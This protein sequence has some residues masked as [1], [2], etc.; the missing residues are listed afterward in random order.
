M[1]SFVAELEVPPGTQDA[2]VLLAS[3]SMIVPL[4]SYF[5]LSPILGFLLAGVLLGPNGLHLVRDVH[6]T[7]VL[8]ELGVVFFLFEMGLELSIERLKS[9]SK[10][11]FGLGTF[12]FVLTTGLLALV[13][14]LCGLPR[15]AA[16]VVGGS[17]ALSSSA[18]VIQLLQER[19][20]LATRFGRASFG[21][22]L[23]QDI[24]VV[25]MLVLVPLLGTAGAGQS[26]GPVLLTAAAK[27]AAALAAIAG[28]GPVLLRKAFSVVS[29][30]KSQEA[31]VAATLFTVLS[32]STF[33]KALGLS[34]T[35][36]AFLAGV[37]LAE[38]RFRYQVEADIAPFRGILFGLF[39]ITIGYAIDIRLL[40][41]N[42]G[43]LTAMLVTL[44]AIKALILIFLCKVA[45][46]S[47]RS[48]IRTGVLLS[49][50]GEFAFVL[51]GLARQHGV[52]D[53]ELA[54]LLLLLAALSMS[55]TPFLAD[56]GPTLAARW[57]RRRR[58]Q[59]VVEQDKDLQD[60]KQEGQVLVCG[61]GRVGQV[62]C[63]LLAN[64]FVRYA[65]C[66][67][68]AELVR[69][70]RDKGLPVYFGDARR[71]D[72]LRAFGLLKVRLARARRGASGASVAHAADSF[73]R[74]ALPGRAPKLLSSP[75]TAPRTACASSRASGVTTP[76]CPSLSV[77]PTSATRRFSSRRAPSASSRAPR[78]RRCSS[79]RRS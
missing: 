35:L 54:K 18:F 41:A 17:L 53:A 62:I 4:M 5:K 70:A 50:A 72:V 78:S 76:T 28:V 46:I 11:A 43:G 69:N 40:I 51:F 44:H 15:E 75:W 79:A 47:S 73:L 12:Q 36:G 61:Y 64:M 23:F 68:D 31:F 26:L 55:A 37:L 3:T 39:F 27:S 34:D 7:E 59:S 32:T 22:L 33:T 67:V 42:A 29:S 60:D 57:E 21:I 14:G 16:L 45:R 74:G 49:Q 52:I 13:A 71:T 6:T 9:L 25:P 48:S 66:D 63:D 24:A 30:S 2:I 65:A 38:S 8:A 10:D 20:E 77:P 56:L 58:R 19:Q 1:H